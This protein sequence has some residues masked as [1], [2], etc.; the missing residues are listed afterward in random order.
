MTGAGF[1]GKLRE[2]KRSDVG[3]GDVAAIGQADTNGV[4]GDGLVGARSL[5][6][7]EV[8]GATSVSNQ[9]R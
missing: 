7:K 1:E 8:T 5:D 4:G 6:H 2:V 9:T 3:G